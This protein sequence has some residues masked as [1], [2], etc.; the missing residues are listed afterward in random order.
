ML[1]RETGLRSHEKVMLG[2]AFVGNF[3]VIDTFLCTRGIGET[4]WVWL[5]ERDLHNG[6]NLHLYLGRIDVA[7]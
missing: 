1:C 7:M 4:N 5:D 6:S 2:L 3:L